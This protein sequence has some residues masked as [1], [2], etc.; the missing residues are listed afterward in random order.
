MP[1][2]PKYRFY[3]DE[4]VR[5]VRTGKTETKIRRQ[6]GEEEKVPNQDLREFDRPV[7]T[8]EKK[9]L[10]L[11]KKINEEK[12]KK[13]KVKKPVEEFPEAELEVVDTPEPKLDTKDLMKKVFVD[14]PELETESEPESVSEP[15]PETQKPKLDLKLSQRAMDQ[16][17]VLS[18]PKAAPPETD[19]T[20]YNKQRNVSKKIRHLQG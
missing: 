12:S 8:E 7:T 11:R 5:I 17:A 14:S 4:V 10:E 6:N 16:L 1:R 9:A 13:T 3:A 18:A 20:N 15:E 19:N 2:A